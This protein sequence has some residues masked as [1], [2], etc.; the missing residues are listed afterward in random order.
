MNK[1]FSEWYEKEGKECFEYNGSYTK[2]DLI[3]AWEAA[4]ASCEAI[5]LENFDECEP[6]LKPGELSSK[7]NNYGNRTRN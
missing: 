5:V 1:N 6:W 4:V 2:D 7:V 3:N